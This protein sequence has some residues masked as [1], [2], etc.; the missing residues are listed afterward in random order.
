MEKA[1]IQLRDDEEIRKAA[2]AKNF[3]HY[4]KQSKKQSS[5]LQVRR[6]VIEGRI[7]ACEQ[8][9]NERVEKIRK[10]KIDQIEKK[11]AQELKKQKEIQA[12]DEAKRKEEEDSAAR[13]QQAQEKLDSFK[14]TDLGKKLFENLTVEMILDRNME[15]LFDERVE[16]LRKSKREDKEKLRKQERNV[17]FLII[18]LNLFLQKKREYNCF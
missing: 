15:E 14:K 5:I 3:N 2:L 4:I 13:K 18:I 6:E 10:K 16:M 17:S 12:M 1:I 9:E 11:R 7:E 8:E